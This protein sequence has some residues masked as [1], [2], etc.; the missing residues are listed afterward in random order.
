LLAYALGA[1]SLLAGAVALE[2][3]ISRRRLLRH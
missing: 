1:L 3:A 2:G